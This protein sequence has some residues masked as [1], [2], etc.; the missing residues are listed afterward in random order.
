[1]I[2]IFTGTYVDPRIVPGF[3]YKVRPA[4]SKKRIFNNRALQLISIGMGYAK[5]LTFEPEPNR[6][7]NPQNHFWS[8]SI[9]GGYG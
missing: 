2:F 6:L 7:N 4:E 9:P 3:R 1:M 5:R 8:D